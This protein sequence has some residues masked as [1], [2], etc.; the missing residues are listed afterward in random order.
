MVG[1]GQLKRGNSGNRHCQ[2]VFDG[3][4]QEKTDDRQSVTCEVCRYR[5]SD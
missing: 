4:G 5:W 1:G 3:K 2:L